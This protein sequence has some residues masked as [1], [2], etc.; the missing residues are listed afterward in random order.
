M[1]IPDVN[2]LI[3]AHWKHAADHREY[4][5]WLTAIVNGSNPFGI[6]DLVMSG[7]LRIITNP[8]LFNPPIPLDE[9]LASLAILRNAPNCIV[10]FPGPRHWD[11][12]VDLCK[13]VQAKGNLISDAYHAALAIESGNEWITSDRDYARFPGLRWRHPFA[14]P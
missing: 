14:K 2:V 1:I 7:F 8:K 6:S 12:F 13:K 5:K 9:A 10:V 3:Y 11:I 4:E